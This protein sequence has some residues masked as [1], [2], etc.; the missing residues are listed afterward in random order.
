MDAILF[1]H[2][3]VKLLIGPFRMAE[4]LELAEKNILDPGSL[5][6]YPG[7][8]FFN[9]LVFVDESARQGPGI[10]ASHFQQQHFQFVLVKAKNDTI[11]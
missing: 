10:G 4:Y 1:E 7:G 11:Q 6:Q 9:I 2:I 3:Q 5:A 8:C